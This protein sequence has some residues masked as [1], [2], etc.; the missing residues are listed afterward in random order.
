[1]FNF[2]KR[3]PTEKIKTVENGKLITEEV[4]YDSK[5][6]KKIISINTL[7]IADEITKLQNRISELKGMVQ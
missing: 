3:I 1:M 6:D 7:V 5:G 2:K 4:I